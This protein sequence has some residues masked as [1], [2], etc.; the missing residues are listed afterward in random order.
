ME[1]SLKDERG[2]VRR[3]E[4]RPREGPGV[5]VEGTVQRQFRPRDCLEVAVGQ[6]RQDK[7]NQSAN[8]G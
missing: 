5:W 3:Q 2:V 6:G 7:V 8:P 4:K 1:D